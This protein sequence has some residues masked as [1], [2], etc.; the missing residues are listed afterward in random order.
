V[1][2]LLPAGDCGENEEIEEG[3]R[4]IGSADE[5]NGCNQQRRSLRKA[6]IIT[7]QRQKSTS[8]MVKDKKTKTIQKEKS[9]PLIPE[10]H[11]QANREL[12]I[13][14]KIKRFFPGPDGANGT[15]KKYSV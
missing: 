3:T 5:F 7:S 9:V 4:D 13:G 10:K 12:L 1:S 11:L 8:T 14:Q 15:V 6:K 2:G